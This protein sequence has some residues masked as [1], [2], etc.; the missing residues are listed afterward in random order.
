VVGLLGG[1]LPSVVCV[2]TVTVY[3]IPSVSPLIVQVSVLVVVQVKV[4]DPDVA[5]AV[6]PDADVAVPKLVGAVHEIAAV[7]S[8]GVALTPVGGGGTMAA[9]VTGTGLLL[10][11]QVPPFPSWPLPLPPQQ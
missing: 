4:P 7:V 11:G 8:P 6:Y 9:T 2:T 3:V 10:Q 5:V 1:E